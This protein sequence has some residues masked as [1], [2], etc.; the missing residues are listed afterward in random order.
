MSLYL[1]FLIPCQWPPREPWHTCFFAF[2]FLLAD[3]YG[4]LTFLA[5][6]FGVLGSVLLLLVL[7]YICSRRVSVL[8]TWWG[9]HNG[10]WYV[11]VWVHKLT[12]QIWV[13]LLQSRVLILHECFKVQFFKADKLATNPAFQA[14]KFLLA[15]SG[16]GGQILGAASFLIAQ[17]VV[18]PSS[19]IQHPPGVMSHCSWWK[20][21]L[22]R[23]FSYR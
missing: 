9:L 12:W 10:L 4:C 14:G 20:R 2:W 18:H 22:V 1:H 21:S 7:F 11:L 6:D 17:L 5:L 15:S 3:C 16:L 13:L 8:A 23:R 19:I